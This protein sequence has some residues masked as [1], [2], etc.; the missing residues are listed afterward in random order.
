MKAVLL[1]GYGGPDVMA[2]GEAPTPEAG[3]G[4]VLIRVV[5]AGVNRADLLQRQGNYPPPKGA[6]D[7][8]GM[9]VS[10][11]I[12]AVGDG[13]DHWA[14]GDPC[15]ALLAGGGYAEF[16]AA[17]AGQVVRPPRGVDLVA[18]GGLIEVAATVVSNFDAVSVRRGEIVLVHG[19]AGGI[20]SFAIP[21]ARSL[22][23]RVIATA[24]TADKRAY[25]L[26]RGADAAVDYHDDWPAEV[27]RLTD[28]RGADVILDVMGASYLEPNVRSLA[29]GGRL[30]VIGMQ[31]GRKGILD[32]GRLMT[33]RGSV[34]AT[35]LRAR[36]V[37]EKAAICC[38]V[39]E[40][41]WPLVGSGAISPIPSTTFPL[42]EAAEAHRRLE[43]G[44]NIGKVI[45]T[46]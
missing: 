16:V 46:A 38:R 42:A 30:I 40:S 35:T 11:T 22:G 8:L 14:V 29:V 2:L 39:A 36:P 27:A 37:E 23:A 10:G 34:L 3:A 25:C 7:I 21:Y 13:V 24:G 28:E 26:D 19:G 45:L 43:S 1:S 32:L 15:V 44:E 9:E 5:A 17:P 31:G 4:E 12:A 33:I 6:S 18:A 20:G 41:V